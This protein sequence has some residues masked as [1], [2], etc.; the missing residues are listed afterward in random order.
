MDYLEGAVAEAFVKARTMKAKIPGTS[1]LEA[2]FDALAARTDLLIDNQCVQL[3]NLQ[4]DPAYQDPANLRQKVSSYR[5]IVGEL[6]LLENVAVAALARSNSDDEYVNRLVRAICREIGYPIQKPVASCLSQSYYHIY[7]EYGLLC[8]PLLESD[9][10]LHIADI[11]HELCHPLI[12]GD[13]PRLKGFQL[14]FGRFNVVAKRHFGQ[15]IARYELNTTRTEMVELSYI[16][17]E[18]WI[19]KWSVE[20]FCDLFGLY[21]LG[22]AYAWSNI[23]LCIKT[24][25]DPYEVPHFIVTSHPPDEAR[26]QALL[27]GL[28]L[29]GYP[30]ESAQIQMRWTEY[31]TTMQFVKQGEYALAVPDGILQQMVI[32]AFA[33]VKALPCKLAYPAEQGSVAKVLNNAWTVFWQNPGGFPDWEQEIVNT[34]KEDLKKGAY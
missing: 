30:K 34:F 8:M 4:E 33:A 6:S 21:T 5:Q 17:R 32:S 2:E 25:D 29:L 26:M 23:H 16:W 3:R 28:D 7:S 12:L 1:H 11:Y 9:F 18:C 14:E 19:T 15:E 13:N 24:G 10:L 22:P 20:F 31:K 27:Y